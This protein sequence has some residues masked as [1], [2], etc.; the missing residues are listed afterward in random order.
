MPL[1][2]VILKPGVNRE[3]TRYTNE[4]GY[5]E[6]E[7][8][9]FRQGTPEKI[10][11]WVQI[12]PSTYT[13]VCR[14]LWN[15]TTLTG[16]NLL[17]VGT[18]DKFYIEATGAYYDITP[19]Y[20]TSTLG[21]APFTTVSGSAT[22]TVTDPYYSPQVGDF[23]IFS[24]ASTFNGVTINGE[25]EVKTVPTSTTYTITSA[26]TASGATTLSG[27]AITGTAGQFS[28]TASTYT[29]VV[30]Q[31]VTISG[32]YGGTGSI[33]GYTSPTKYYIVA[34]NGS[35]TFTL[36]T[37]VG[38]AGVTTTAGT[39]TGLTYSGAGG[40]T[41]VFASYLLHIGSA[42][43]T[44]FSGWGG[45]AW[46]PESWGGL[47]YASTAT[48]AIWS[49]WNFGQNLVFGPKLGKLYYWNA[50]PAVNLAVPTTITIT[51]A[52]PAVCTLTSN[53][54]TPIISGTAIMF[55]TTGAL[56]TPLKPYTRYFVTKDTVNDT[57]K[58]SLSY[59]DY[60]AGTFINTGSA[61]SGIHSLSA[62]GIAVEDLAGASSVPIQQ[63]TILVSD[64]SR[65]TMCFGANPYGST[66]YDPMTIRWSNQES[67]VEWAPAV[68]NQAG[69]IQLSHGS[70]IVSVLQ[71]R[72]EVL[73]WTDAALYSLQYLGPPYVWGNQLLSDNISIA[74]MNAAS[75]ASGVSYWMGKDKFYK[76][77]GR[78]QTL[79]CD[80]R[81]Y[82]YSDINRTQFD[83]VFSGTNEGFNEVWWF[84]CSEGSTTVD[85]YV[86]YNYAE[87]LW[88]Y[89]SMA[90][91]AWLDTA[92]RD[93]PI[94]A[95]YVNN[96]VYHE[97]GVDDGTTGTLAP[98]EASI[99]SAQF[100]IGD[101]HNFAFVYRMLPDLTFRGSTEGTT[102]SVTMY[103]QGLNNSGSGI[104]QTGSAA[105]NYSGSAPSVINVDEYT[106]QIYIRIRGRQMQMKLTSNTLGTQWQLGAPR[107]DLRADGRR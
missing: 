2:K 79:R 86:I 65:F 88:Y 46:L 98:I 73:V 16:A 70:L 36:S 89:G 40:G 49:Q 81:Q 15:W 29:L 99:T 107:I 47:G 91:T 37:T 78:V 84:Y 7:K 96:L 55:Q 12:S 43:N 63:N 45:N 27:V 53:T 97:F 100:D 14:S 58:L 48:L 34:T 59:V 50:T 75:Y 61:G 68:T 9:R 80:L 13:G 23:V 22:V 25:Y 51:N 62:R 104:T 56:P 39:P 11:G 67:V 10:G 94:A 3:N 32:T 42:A 103:L 64:S 83:Q 18:S 72:Q 4:G 71:S 101:G 92:L 82:I 35:T 6:S 76:Y 1:Q 105:V 20:T 19:I 5:Y 85:K 95:T 57:F 60:L 77:D 41:A 87:D 17:G 24:G 74:S 44:T 69:E 33:S 8:I 66:T 38:G 26:T 93:Y 52:S 30:G 54:T 28:C 102:P 106:G 21:A 31:S 90:R